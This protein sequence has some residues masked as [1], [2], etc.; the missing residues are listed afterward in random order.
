MILTAGTQ[1]QDVNPAVALAIEQCRIDV[2]LKSG[3]AAAAA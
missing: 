2:F 1:Q 3:R